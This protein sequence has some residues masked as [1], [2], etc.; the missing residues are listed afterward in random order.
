MVQRRRLNCNAGTSWHRWLLEG[1]DP[2]GAAFESDERRRI[3]LEYA[4]NAGFAMDT[5]C[6]IGMF[7]ERRSRR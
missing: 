2:Q 7:D 5:R 3:K 6:L 4:R 1:S